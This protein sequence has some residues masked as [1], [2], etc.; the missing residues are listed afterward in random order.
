MTGKTSVKMQNNTIPPVTS[1]SLGLWGDIKTAKT[2]LACSA[3]G[4]IVHF[5]LDQGF[6]RATG[7]LR[8][9]NF[10]IAPPGQLSMF[11]VQNGHTLD[12]NS[13][14]TIPY[15][16]P[17]QFPGQAVI[18]YVDLLNLVIADV[19]CA[20]PDAIIRSI[21][22]DTGTVMYDL[23]TKAALERIQA[24]SKTPRQR[25][26][27]MEYSRPNAELRAIYGA[28]KTYRK[29]L[30]ITHHI[31]GVYQD[32]LTERGV[33]SQRVGDTWAGFAGLGAIVDMIGRTAIGV[34][35]AGNKQPMIQIETSG[36]TLALEGQI[37]AFPGELTNTAFDQILTMINTLRNAGQ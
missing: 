7:Q 15:Q 27:R 35:D 34:D 6:D 14:I 18:G 10:H 3:P 28:Q 4:P 36:Y 33:D 24:T 23:V 13:I 11:M 2:S 9:K 8:H 31:G 22:V 5:D 21:I 25:L 16:M 1:L 17:I 20:Y 37:L 32:V 19:G 26:Q 12:A 29:N 30:I